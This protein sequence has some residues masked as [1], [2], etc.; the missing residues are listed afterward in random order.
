MGE[1]AFSSTTSFF[2]ST[3]E[4]K[5]IGQVDHD[6]RVFIA[7]N[8]DKI[9]TDIARG[10]GEYGKSFFFILTSDTGRAVNAFKKAKMQFTDLVL[11]SDEEEFYSRL[12]NCL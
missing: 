12:K 10:S 2:S 5:M 4:C 9:L 7:H 8:K 3:G 11:I 6:A 1:G